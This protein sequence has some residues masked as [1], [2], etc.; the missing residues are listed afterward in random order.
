MYYQLEYYE[1]NL[2]S[3]LGIDDCLSLI[4]GQSIP[5]KDEEKMFIV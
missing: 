4:Y 5:V 1:K 2:V 3:I